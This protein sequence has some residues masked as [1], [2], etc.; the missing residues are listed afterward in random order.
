MKKET[1]LL[2]VFGAKVSKDG[3]KLVLVLVGGEED[4]RQFYN[5]CVKLDNSQKTYASID[6]VNEVATLEV[7]LLKPKNDDN[8]GLPF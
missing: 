1:P 6:E 2:S 7:P 8:G 5:A 3:Q 4:N